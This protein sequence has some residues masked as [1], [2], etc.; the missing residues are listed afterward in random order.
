MGELTLTWGAKKDKIY[1]YLGT[2]EKGGFSSS[3]RYIIPGAT[4]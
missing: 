2:R 1:A 4:A 3:Q